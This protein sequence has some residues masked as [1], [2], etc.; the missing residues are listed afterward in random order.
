MKHYTKWSVWITT[1][2]LTLTVPQFT[3]A[4]AN[5][6]N[7][8]ANS[9]Q[10]GIGVVSGWVCRANRVEIVFDSFGP[11]QASSGL[12][13]G[14]TQTVCGDTDNGFGFLVNWN[15]LGDGQHTVRVLADGV[16]IGEATQARQREA[17]AGHN[18]EEHDASQQHVSTRH[19]A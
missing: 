1:L 9:F 5:L 7:P 17:H 6:E 12:P 16:A 10:S 3:W 14:D 4:Q 2:M 19:D 11:F 18:P 8:Q 13:H 15:L